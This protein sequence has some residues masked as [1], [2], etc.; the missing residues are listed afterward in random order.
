MESIQKVFKTSEFKG[1]K[2]SIP[3]PRPGT[4]KQMTRLTFVESHPEMEDRVF[5]M[6]D[7]PLLVSQH[8]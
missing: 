3:K 2:E 1:N 4:D 7:Q 5:S 8:H 6:G